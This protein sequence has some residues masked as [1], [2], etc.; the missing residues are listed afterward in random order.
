[1]F[2]CKH[3]T[4]NYWQPNMTLLVS[5]IW[6]IL[7]AIMALM[8]LLFLVSRLQPWQQKL[9]LVGFALKKRIFD[10][11]A[12]STPVFVSEYKHIFLFFV[13]DFM[14]ARQHT[15]TSCVHQQNKDKIF[16][17]PDFNLVIL[18]ACLWKLEIGLNPDL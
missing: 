18:L 1:M 2:K 15:R 10:C 5:L 4:Q 11:A 8:L 12:H 9:C 6:H 14:L 17:Q 7:T 16:N 13:V 3:T